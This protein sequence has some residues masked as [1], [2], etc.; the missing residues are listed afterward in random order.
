MK[1]GPNIPFPNNPSAFNVS[2]SKISEKH[3]PLN[4]YTKITCMSRNIKYLDR[5]ILTFVCANQCSL[6]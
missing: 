5:P 6:T 2:V 3:D 1:F 4:I